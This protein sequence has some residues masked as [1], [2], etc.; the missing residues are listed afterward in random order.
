MATPLIALTD[1]ERQ[2]AASRFEILR[3]FLQERV[4][5]THMARQHQ[6]PLRTLTRWVQRYHAEGL[7]GLVR[8]PRSDHGRRRLN[9][10]LQQLIEGL[11][12]QNPP[13]SVSAIHRQVTD[14]A[15]QHNLK[16]PSYG[17]VYAIVN[18][19]SPALTTLA[20]QGTKAYAQQ[21]D[22]LYRREAHAP[23]VIW[24]ADHCLLD[25]L[26]LREGHKPAKPWLTVILDDYSRAMAG[27]FL[28]FDAPS[29]L[30][31]SLAL[32]QAIW[33]KGEPRWC[34]C[35][36]PQILYSDCGSDFKSQHLEQVS[37]DLKI[38]LTNSIPG[39]PRGRGR[40]ERFF[41]T[42]QQMFLCELPGYAPPE[43]TVRG[44]PRLTLNDLET[45]FRTFVLDIYHERP[46]SET[47]E[48]PR[49]RWEAGGFLP[50]MPDSLEQLDLL[51]LTVAKPRKVRRDGIWF[52]GLRYM[53]PTL[54]AYVG[55]FVIL[56]Y[57]PR[58]MAEVRVFYQ[59]HFLCRAIC[60]ELAGAT[61]SL[62]EIMKARNR[63]RRD[64]RQTLRDRERVVESLL[65][66]HRGRPSA[67]ETSVNTPP[68]DADTASPPAS[69]AP[70]LKRY[71]NE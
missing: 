8:K 20:H 13:L 10:T 23:N 29:A 11:A 3:P 66:A 46:H 33:R 70:K 25:I 32:R 58:D 64:L 6:L 9:P 67:A 36:I 41:R 28:T 12:L 17:L 37:M 22:L 68:P 56:R 51:L 44:E 65:A 18:D 55:E 43:G 38:R 1:S 69:Q 52:Q 24:Q 31:T 39:Q 63:H 54:A 49:Q 47:H 14:L 34:M 71:F 42:V 15:G 19:L 4:P 59:D 45:R 61:V 62:R 40:I 30:N 53:D 16:P 60:Q 21:F 26:V 50:Q 5:L 35:G 57:D 7:A 2:L 48:P 27:Y